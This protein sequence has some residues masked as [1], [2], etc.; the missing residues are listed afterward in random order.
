LGAKTPFKTNLLRKKIREILK[1]PSTQRFTQTR[2]ILK[3]NGKK[4]S[5]F[6]GLSLYRTPKMGPKIRILK[7]PKVKYPKRKE[8]GSKKGTMEKVNKKDKFTLRRI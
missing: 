2:R 7:R 5:K 3:L 6:K 1:W 4:R 8:Y